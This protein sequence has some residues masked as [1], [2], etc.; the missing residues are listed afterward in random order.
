GPARTRRPA[1]PAGPG[2]RDPGLGALAVGRRESRGTARTD[3][4]VRGAAAGGMLPALPSAGLAV[5]RAAHDV[6]Q[7]GAAARPVRRRPALAREGV[8]RRGGNV[9]RLPRLRDVGRRRLLARREWRLVPP[10]AGQGPL[11]PVT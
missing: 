5:V 9:V 3:R 8:S 11:R 1:E 6:R 7:R 4:L 2:V 10:R